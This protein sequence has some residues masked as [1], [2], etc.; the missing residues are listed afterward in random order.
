MSS[1][2]PTEVTNLR[3]VGAQ[4]WARSLSLPNSTAAGPLDRVPIVMS[5][6]VL[7]AARFV[8]R[9]TESVGLA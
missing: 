3:H 2:A 4:R 6:S 7:M 9:D 5:T 8:Q 1:P